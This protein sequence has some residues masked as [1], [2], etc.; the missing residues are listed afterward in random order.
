MTTNPPRR[1]LALRRD[2]LFRALEQKGINPDTFLASIKKPTPYTSRAPLTP[3][4]LALFNSVNSSIATAK[5]PK[6][7]TALVRCSTNGKIQSEA[8]A[9]AHLGRLVWRAALNNQIL[10]D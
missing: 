2:R 8:G 7:L 5:T 4:E 6:A 1:Y 10:I 9:L 3:A